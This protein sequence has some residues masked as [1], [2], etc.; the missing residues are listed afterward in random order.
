MERQGVNAVTLQ[1]HSPFIRTQ[2]CSVVPSHSDGKC[3]DANC[4]QKKDL[5]V[6]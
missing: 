5:G 6:D 2:I 3:K 1:G 4:I